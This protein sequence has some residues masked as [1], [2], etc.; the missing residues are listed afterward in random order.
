MISMRVDP[1]IAALIVAS[2]ALLFA[3]A[4]VHKLRDL[5]RF[6]EIFSAYGL[7]PLHARAPVSVLVPITEMGVAMG[8][9][10]GM[11]GSAA[12]TIGTP[13]VLASAIG[14]LLM[15]SYAL[16]I[17]IN[18]RRGRR[19]LACGCGGPDERR[20]IAAWMVWRN[21]L[22]AASLAT[23]VLPWSARPLELTDAVTIGLG[24]VTF[25]L[26][27]LC[28]DRVLGQAARRTAELRVSR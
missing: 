12:G 2:V 8:L 27:Y 16:A 28:L 17:A 20:P 14:C 6:R 23:T 26:I 3:S 11:T 4:A 21:L 24:V 5:R 9:L 18:L 22:I 25:A 1:A 7:F 15:L 13:R 10:I 19:D